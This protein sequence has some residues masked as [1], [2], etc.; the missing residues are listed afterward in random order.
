MSTTLTMSICKSCRSFKSRLAVSSSFYACRMLDG[1]EG[2]D[3]EGDKGRPQV[4]KQ[5]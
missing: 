2:R 4:V 1:A 3:G 5:P